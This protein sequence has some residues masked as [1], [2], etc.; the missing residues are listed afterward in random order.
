VGL[1]AGRLAGLFGYNSE[2]MPT[3]PPEGKK[4]A[5]IMKRRNWPPQPK[6]E[7]SAEAWETDS[8][9]GATIFSCNRI[10]RSGGERG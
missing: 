9:R 7:I 6:D 5:V 1:D 10:A 8:G 4:I 3:S 2:A